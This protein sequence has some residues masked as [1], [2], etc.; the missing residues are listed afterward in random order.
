MPFHQPEAV[1]YLTFESLD[2]AGVAH[3]VFTRQGGVSP[4]P[5][6]SLNVGGLRGDDPAR[7]LENR[8]RSFRALG[9]DPD[10]VY[11]V[12][13]VHSTDVIC[14]RAPRPPHPHLKADAILTDQ[15][16]VTLF[17]RFGDCV[18]IL[19]YDPLRRVVGLTHAGWLGTVRGVVSATVTRMREAYGSR[20][21]DVLAAIGPSIGAHHYAVGPDVVAQARQSFGEEADGLLPQANGAVHFDLWAANRL[22][23]ERA[24]VRQIEISGLCTAC[25]LEDWYSHRGE[26]GETGRF[27]VLVGLS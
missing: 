9:R 7:V 10:S 16:L 11:D 1:R 23:L 15:P 6:A 19:L 13:Q 17:M 25:H 20:P 4:Q 24:G 3:A 22:L 8:V 18:P 27:G 14:S 2:A 21:G 26:R 5:W 12:W